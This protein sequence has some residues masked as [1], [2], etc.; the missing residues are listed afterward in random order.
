MAP[1]A[2]S[3]QPAGNEIKMKSKPEKEEPEHVHG[4]EDMTPLQAISHNWKETGLV[5]G[6]IENY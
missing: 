6:G 1:S 5:I 3:E 2:I 4:A